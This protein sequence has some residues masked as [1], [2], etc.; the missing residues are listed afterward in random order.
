M[1]LHAEANRK[2]N[3]AAAAEAKQ[4]AQKLAEAAK[5]IRKEIAERA[6][7]EV[8][9]IGHTDR[10][11]TLE[12][13]DTLS[14]QRAETVREHILRA[15]IQPLSIEIA[16]CLQYIALIFE[17]DARDEIAKHVTG[18]DARTDPIKSLFGSLDPS[19]Q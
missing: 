17:L 4:A 1:F 2:A 5:D 14:L 18:F 19:W 3:E 11:G 9:V 6:A 16:G 7:S 13:N 15:G 12:S 8:M 10:V